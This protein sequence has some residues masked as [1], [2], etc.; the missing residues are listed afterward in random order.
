[1]Y[2]AVPKSLSVRNSL[3]IKCYPYCSTLSKERYNGM[4]ADVFPPKQTGT[5]GDILVTNG[6]VVPRD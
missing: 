4:V 1:M 5:F 6:A 3:S 2:S